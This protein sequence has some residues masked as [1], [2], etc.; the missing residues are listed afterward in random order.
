MARPTFL[1]ALASAASLAAP[2]AALMPAAARYDVQLIVRDGDAA[3]TRPRLLVEAGHPA[4]FQIANQRYNL[5]VT[6][7]PDADNKVAVSSHITTWLRDGL[8]NDAST[9]SLEA[10]GAMNTVLAPHTDP[11]TGAVSGMRIEVSV[12][13]VGG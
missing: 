10:D 2:A 5:R 8:Y 9:L 4:T 1:F 6:A 12:R 13:P 3:P 7:T 11:E